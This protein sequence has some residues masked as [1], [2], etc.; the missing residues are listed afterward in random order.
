MRHRRML[1]PIN[2]NKH[3][4]ARTNTTIAAGGIANLTI[5]SAVVA[6]ASSNTF[7]VTEGAVIKAVHIEMWINGSGAAASSTQA[8]IIVEKVPA[9]QV[10]VTVAQIVNLQAYPNKK[11]ILFTFQGVLGMQ[12]DGQS[13]IAPIRDWLLIPKGK[14]RFGFGD[15]LII[16][17][18]SLTT[19]LQSCGMFIY[20][21]YR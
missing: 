9:G 8:I 6:P 16:S 4:V 5:A 18:S 2:T 3:F 21:E 15:K 20:K 11:N 1:A 19:T 12:R 7:D 14:Q 10:S 13:A 17:I